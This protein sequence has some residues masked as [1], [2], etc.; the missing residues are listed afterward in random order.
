MKNRN[1]IVKILAKSQNLRKFIF[2]KKFLSKNFVKVSNTS[3]IEKSN[4]LIFST[5]IAFTILRQV[6][7][8]VPIPQWFV[9][10]YYI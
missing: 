10:K 2:R 4:F 7:T 1:K 3:I 6:F 8:K 9:L 5:R